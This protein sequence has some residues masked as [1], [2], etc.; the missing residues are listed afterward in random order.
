ME[1][2]RR[3]NPDLAPDFLQA[4]VDIGAVGFAVAAVAVVRRMRYTM[5]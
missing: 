1:G 3:Y 4:A 2:R 5:R